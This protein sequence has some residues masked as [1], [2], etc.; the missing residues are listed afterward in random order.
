ML[1]F[2]WLIHFAVA[3]PDDS[4]DLKQAEEFF[5]NGQQLYNESRYGAAIIA[6]QEGYDMTKMPAFLKNIALAQEAMGEYEQALDTLSIYRAYAPHEEQEALREWQETLERELEQ[7]QTEQAQTETANS[8][9]TQEDPVDTTQEVTTVEQVPSETEIPPE[10]PGFTWN[11]VWSAGAATGLVVGSSLLTFQAMS[12]HN[13]ILD[14]CQSIGDE[15]ICLSSTQTLQSDLNDTQRSA[16]FLWGA[17]AVVSSVAV[18]QFTQQTS[19][20]ATPTSIS[21]QG[22]F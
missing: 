15:R 17:S 21:L 16:L 2:T 19:V 12:L 22:R 20:H 10:E 9:E 13:Q 11:P 6:W 18:W 3:E 5:L 4:V 8:S 14:Q 1:L 7:R